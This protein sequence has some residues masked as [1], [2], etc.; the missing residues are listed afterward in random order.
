MITPRLIA[1][2]SRT[3]FGVDGDGRDRDR[4]YGGVHAVTVS[5]GTFFLGGLTLR[6]GGDQRLNLLLVI[7]SEREQVSYACIPQDL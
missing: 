5:A 6:L 1:G 4:H 7:G 2:G 3:E